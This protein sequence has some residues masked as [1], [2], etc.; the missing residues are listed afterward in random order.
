[1]PWQSLGKL[2]DTEMKA[3]WKYLATL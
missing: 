1:M 2:T 3:L